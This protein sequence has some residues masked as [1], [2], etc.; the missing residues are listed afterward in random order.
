MPNDGLEDVA[1][2]FRRFAER[3]A[4]PSSPL[5]SQLALEVSDDPSI[6]RLAQQATSSPITSLL[7]AAIHD[8]LLRGVEHPLRLFY[9]DLT[10]EPLPLEC[11][12]PAFCSFCREYEA[13]IVEL[14]TTRRV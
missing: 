13:D 9:P 10:P 1:R 6:L 7:F 12:F 5:Y 2:R 14:L 4:L 8:L 3:Q 11:A